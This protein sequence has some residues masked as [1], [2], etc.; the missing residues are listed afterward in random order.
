MRRYFNFK[1]LHA[2]LPFI[3]ANASIPLIGVMNIAIAGHLG[4]SD[5]LAA[6]SIGSMVVGILFW[7]LSSLRMGTTG[8]IAQASGQGD[9]LR[10]NNILSNS[11]LLAIMISLIAWLCHSPILSS[12]RHHTTRKLPKTTDHGVLQHTTYRHASGTD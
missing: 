6:L 3:L 12:I 4:S 1:I 9:T 11:F 8:L 5:Y 2:A 7:W 10:M